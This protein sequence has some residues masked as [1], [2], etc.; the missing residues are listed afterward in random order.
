MQQ[1]KTATA[2]PLLTRRPR[3]YTMIFDIHA[4]IIES[5]QVEEEK[6]RKKKKAKQ[7]RLGQ[8]PVNVSLAVHSL[9]S[10]PFTSPVGLQPEDF[11]GTP[12]PLL[13]FDD[14]M[15]DM[16]HTTVPNGSPTFLNSP[17]DRRYPELSSSP[18]QATESPVRRRRSN[19]R[20]HQRLHEDTEWLDILSRNV[21]S[22][23]PVD[24]GRVIHY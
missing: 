9:E 16:R 11:F 5:A 2:Y 3:D 4:N 14:Y 18:P 21:S 1:V 20:R 22:S 23:S 13:N 19:Q 10:S 6:Q 15:Q 7:R 12:P 8:L 24:I 17:A